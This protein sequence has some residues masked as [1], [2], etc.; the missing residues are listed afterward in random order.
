M[1]GDVTLSKYVQKG[2]WT[3][4]GLTIT[5]VH[6]NERHEEGKDYGFEL[7]V[8]SPL[9]DLEAPKFV[10]GSITIGSVNKQEED[11]NGI[12]RNYK[13]WDI[14][15]RAKED[16]PGYGVIR[17]APVE[18]IT[19]NSIDYFLDLEE[20]GC[21]HCRFKSTEYWARGAWEIR[22]I[23]L[24]DVAGNT[25]NI[26][27]SDPELANDS[28][29]FFVDSE[30]PDTEGPTIDVNTIS[31]VASPTNPDA[32]NGETNVTITFTIR[33]NL[34]GFSYATLFLIDPQGV[35]H[36]FDT[37]NDNQYRQD[38]YLGD[39]KADLIQKAKITLPAGS[40]PGKWGLADMSVTD[41]VG[42]MRYYDF[43]E[44]ITF[45]VSDNA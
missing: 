14:K 42:N 11:R 7:F 36:Q 33:D 40:A 35:R 10:P 15:L 5:D 29:Q 1:E 22:S 16:H 26:N 24:H 6:G 3:G 38:Y 39:P 2:Y 20:D 4:E 17:I 19:V 8:D 31:I 43:T 41:L 21:Y 27:S 34:S 18:D 28:I 13:E 32:P 25:K 12:L 44:T 37:Y 30:N 9:E 23:S 45:T